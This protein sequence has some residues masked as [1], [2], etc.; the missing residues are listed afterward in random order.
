MDASVTLLDQLIAE[1]LLIR[2]GVEGLYGRSGVFEDVIVRFE[3]LVSRVGGADGAEVIRFPPAMTRRQLETS[4][5]MK[6]FPQL[7]GT[8]H[9]FCG[10]DHDHMDLL[11]TLDEGGDWTQKQ[12]AT[13]IAL[14]PA[15][16]YPLYPM[17]AAQGP[18]PPGGRLFDVQSYCFR[19]EPSADPARMQL[20]RM[21]EYVRAGT[22][23]EVQAF[24]QRWIERAEEMIASLDLPYE[25]VPANDPFFGRAGRMMKVNQ[26]E[27]GLKLEMVIPVANAQPTACLSFNYHQDHFAHTWG[28][29]LADGG[30]AHTSCVGF[31]L[32]RIALALFRHH[33]LDPAAWPDNVRRVLWG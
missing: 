21:R 1:G 2:T 22:A 6:S 31:G 3:A 5:Y 32:E 29:R 24:R 28:V 10:G 20:F 30:P 8:V 7:A 9:S 19:H 16:C 4:G 25:V 33:G 26:R 13:D 17:V 12:E 23:E 11:A 27:Q 18:L 15:A 14:T